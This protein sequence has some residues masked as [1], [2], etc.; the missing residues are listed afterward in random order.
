[1]KKE[2]SLAPHLAREIVAIREPTGTVKNQV[3]SGFVW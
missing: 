3:L 1:M 2:W